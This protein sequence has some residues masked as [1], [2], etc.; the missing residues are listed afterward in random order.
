MSEPSARRRIAFSQRLGVRLHLL[1]LA[2]L[3]L[4]ALLFGLSEYR[5]DASTGRNAKASFASF[6]DNE[7]PR[8]SAAPGEQQRALEG[9]RA[10]EMAQLDIHADL[11]LFDA[12]RKLIARAGAALPPPDLAKTADGWQPGHPYVFV[13][14]LAD[15]RWLQ[16]KQVLVT[17]LFKVPQA[18]N[19]I[20]GL[21]AISLAVVALGVYPF[22]R[23]LTRRLN[24][25]Q[26]S[27]AAWGDKD[28][29][30]RMAVEGRDEVAQLANSFNRAA[31]RIESLVVA[32]TSLLD[33][34]AHQLRAPLAH[35][36]AVV[37]QLQTRATPAIREELQRNIAELDQLTEEVMLASRLDANGRTERLDETVDLAAIAAEEC[38]RVGASMDCVGASLL[39]DARLLRRMVR[40]LLENAGRYGAGT[41]VT[42]AV[43][44]D[45][46]GVLLDVCDCGPGIPEAQR[47]RV[48]E[49][50]YRVPGA[51]EAAGG[52]GLGLSLVRQI[53]RHHGGSVECLANAEGG[54]CFRVKMPGDAL[55]TAT[56]ADGSV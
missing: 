43:R 22:T 13:R 9:W 42:V 3:A 11:A 5:V 19:Y 54:C 53:A 52:V 36:R 15:G 33:N 32:Q 4:V 23:G 50:F 40:N 30:A 44:R 41:A 29:S 7:L 1:L 31:S 2:V 8:A 24:R 26:D 49:P 55:T 45:A 38:A 6:V 28:L 34:A 20:A 17:P 56:N 47:E 27:L 25:L 21:C 51:S 39:G 14:E 37:E 10:R 18:L 48:F 46:E 12:E 35:I 16:S